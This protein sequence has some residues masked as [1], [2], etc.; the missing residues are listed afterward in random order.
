[1]GEAGPLTDVRRRLEANSAHLAQ[2]PATVL[3]A[4]MDSVPAG[5]SRR[6]VRP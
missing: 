3:H 4:V 2:G 1:M 6:P 5:V